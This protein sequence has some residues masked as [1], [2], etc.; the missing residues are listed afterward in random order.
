MLHILLSP[1]QTEERCG[2]LAQRICRVSSAVRQDMGRYRHVR[3]R[4][5]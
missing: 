3:V 2:D 5:R 1:E 4:L